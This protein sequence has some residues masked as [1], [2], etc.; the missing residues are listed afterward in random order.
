M[1]L[2]KLQNLGQKDTDFSYECLVKMDPLLKYANSFQT[3]THYQT[4]KF[5]ISPK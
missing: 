3:L 2:S 5:Y 4:T 1:F